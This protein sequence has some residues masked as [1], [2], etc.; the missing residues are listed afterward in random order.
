M[1]REKSQKKEQGKKGNKGVDSRVLDADAWVLETGSDEGMEKAKTEEEFIQDLRSL[2]DSLEKAY[3]E[4]GIEGIQSFLAGEECRKL[5]GS[6]VPWLKYNEQRGRFLCRG[7]VNLMDFQKAKGKNEVSQE[8]LEMM[9]KVL[10][11]EGLSG[12]QHCLWKV[13]TRTDEYDVFLAIFPHEAFVYVKKRKVPLEGRS[14][15]NVSIS[16]QKKKLLEDAIKRLKAKGQGKKVGSLS[17]FMVEAAW[18]IA[19]LMDTYGVTMKK[20]FEAAIMHLEDK[21]ET[22][23]LQKKV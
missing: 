9:Q 23:K 18:G 6:L 10:D 12:L 19:T 15:I 2:D 3:K 16:N 5:G 8:I 7:F 1:K 13:K 21:E 22:D 14:K 4:N 20:V 17:S 11:E